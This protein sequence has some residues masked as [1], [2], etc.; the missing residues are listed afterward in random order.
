MPLT[1]L[2]SS[3]YYLRVATDGEKVEGGGYFG[4][5]EHLA[6]RHLGTTGTI[7]QVSPLFAEANSGRRVS[8]RL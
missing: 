5:Q 6:G 8:R 3:C 1:L 4:D 7:T 2:S